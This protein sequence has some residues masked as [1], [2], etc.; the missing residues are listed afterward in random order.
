MP[1]VARTDAEERL[2]SALRDR[3]QLDGRSMRQ[4]EAEIGLGHGTLGNA[5]RGRSE[6]RFHHLERLGAVLRFTVPEIV[7]EAYGETGEKA[8]LR[9]LLAEVVRR[10]LDTLR[11]G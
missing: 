4:I 10:E 5:L 11:K 9:S 1:T 6:L 3:L 8:A 2:L 7:A